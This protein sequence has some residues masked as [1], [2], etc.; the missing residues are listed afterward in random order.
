M[1]TQQSLLS[2]SGMPVVSTRHRS[3]GGIRSAQRGRETT[4][5]QSDKVRQ[6]MML[7]TS[8]HLP[9]VY[10]ISVQEAGNCV[11]TGALNLGIM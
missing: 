11:S 6:A 7:T 9:V 4:K 10:W 1:I 2:A 5:S 3:W 8:P